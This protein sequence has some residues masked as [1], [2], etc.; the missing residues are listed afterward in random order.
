MTG[1][2][3]EHDVSSN[4]HKLLLIIIHSKELKVSNK[5]EM[6]LHLIHIKSSKNI[7]VINK[8]STV[9]YLV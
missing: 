2:P 1:D 5:K 6:F 7:Y 9:F 8:Q 3:N 4:K